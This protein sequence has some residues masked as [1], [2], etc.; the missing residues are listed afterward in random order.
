MDRIPPGPQFKI[1]QIFFFFLDAMIV[2]FVTI[3]LHD[4]L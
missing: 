4:K 2:I 3:Y 1:I